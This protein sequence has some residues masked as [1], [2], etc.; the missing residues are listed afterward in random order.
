MVVT[1]T[2][3]PET[4][5]E[6]EPTVAILVLALLHTPPVIDAVSGN[7]VPIHTCTPVVVPAP[8]ITGFG[9]MTTLSLQVVV[10]LQP[11]DGL[12]AVTV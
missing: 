1:P 7:A 10:F 5:P 6:E 9:L 12:N 3:T 11:V 2:V 8:D 4:I